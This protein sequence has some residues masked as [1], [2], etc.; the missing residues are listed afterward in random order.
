MTALAGDSRRTVLVTGAAGQD[1]Q[2]LVRALRRR[3]DD[4]H[5]A[6]LPAE[7]EQ[8]P[9]WCAVQTIDLRH[10]S[11]VRRLVEEVDPEVVVNL[12]GQSSVASSWSNPSATVKVNTLTVSHL[13]DA[14]WH[15]QDATGSRRVFL[16]ASSAEIFGD[17]PSAPQDE[18]TPLRP[19]NPYGASKAAAH[20]LVE[21]Y[22]VHG[23][24]ASNLVLYPHES[25]LRPVTFVVRKIT[26]GVA[27]IARGRQDVLELGNLEARR[28]WG[29][30]PD[31]ADAFVRASLVDEPADVVVATGVDHAVGDVARVAFEHVG[32]HDW[33]RH[34]VTSPEHRRRADAGL[35]VGDPTAAYERLGWRPSVGFEALVRRLVDYD[36]AVLD[37]ADPDPFED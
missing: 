24:H 8:V 28:D 34:V 21:S 20:L 1:G 3:G 2:Y 14:L 29:W 13:L 12:A 30:A 23:L 19:V 25:P 9:S 10:E 33:R 15:R 37:G 6:V 17:A 27:R 36:L 31:V 5:A 35:L 18:R 32:V 4:V 11:A 16:Q 22:R 7:R 26:H